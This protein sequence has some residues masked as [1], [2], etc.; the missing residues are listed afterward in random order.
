[1]QDREYSG[2]IHNAVNEQNFQNKQ[3]PSLATVSL[4]NPSICPLLYIKP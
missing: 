1:M 3:L 4:D 2:M